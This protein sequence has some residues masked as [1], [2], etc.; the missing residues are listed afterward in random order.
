MLVLVGTIPTPGLPLIQGRITYTDALRIGTDL[1]IPGAHLMHCTTAMMASAAVVCQ[2]LGYD[3]P[4]GIAAGCI[5]DGS[6]SRML[7]KFLCEEAEKLDA[8]V[9]TLHYI[10]PQ[11]KLIK[12]VLDSIQ[13]WKKRPVL[14]GDAGG[15]YAVK[16]AG[17]SQMFDLFTPDPGELAFL[18]DADALHPAYVRHFISEVDTTDMPRLIQRAYEHGDAAKVLLVKGSTDYIVRQGE[19]LTTISE[20]NIAAMEAIGGTG[21]TITGIASA[22]VYGG[23]D[24]VDACKYTAVINRIA[25]QECRPTPATQ[26]GDIIAHIPQAMEQVLPQ[27]AGAV[28]GQSPVQVLQGEG[29]N[30]HA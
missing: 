6:G 25:G 29:G 2:T 3:A 14:I 30:V 17:L 1:E 16:A 5:G 21:D 4:Y 18:S 24:I 12:K 9:L 23:F 20:P 15:M 26:I 27:P 13:V 22:L 28:L 10:V 11:T 7:Y 19:I 8:D